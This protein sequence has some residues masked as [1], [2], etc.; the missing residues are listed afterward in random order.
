MR[1]VEL[2]LLLALA[3]APAHG[4]ALVKRIEEDSGGR[5]SL[6][7]GN[8]YGI[9]HRLVSR[10]LMRESRRGPKPEED[11]RRRLYELTANGRR[12]LRCEAAHLENLVGRMRSRLAETH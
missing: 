9:I 5:L 10:G 8:L 4:Y 2:H 12:A 7:P 1:P 11:Q 3:A 6:L